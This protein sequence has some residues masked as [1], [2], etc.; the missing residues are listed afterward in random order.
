VTRRPLARTAIH[1]LTHLA[2]LSSEVSL[3]LRVSER[4]MYLLSNIA[5]LDITNPQAYA[6]YYNPQAY[7]PVTEA[8]EEYELFED[9]RD[10]AQL[11]ILET[12]PIV[13]ES[14]LTRV[15]A[16]TNVGLLT[17]DTFSLFK[18]N[19]EILDTRSE[20]DHVNGYFTPDESG[21]YIVSARILLGSTTAW[22]AASELLILSM[23]PTSGSDILVFDRRHFN[24]GGVSF[25]AYAGGCDTISLTGDTQYEFRVYQNSGSNQYPIATASLAQTYT[26]LTINRLPEYVHTH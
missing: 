24:V 23:R 8:D 17:N 11:E 2:G 26:R 12:S 7:I 25:Y 22:T 19:Q 1:D 20:F 16:W 13:S 5:A 18:Y 6:L 10:Q 21:S 15:E 4:T 9:V 3:T 14:E